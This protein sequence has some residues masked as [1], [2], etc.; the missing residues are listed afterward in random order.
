MRRWGISEA[1]LPPGSIV[2]FREP[3]VWEQYKG[4]IIAAA[5]LCAVEA[6]LI[7]AL[8]VNRRRLNRANAER[9]QA[10]E[11]AH[12]LSGRLINAQEQERSRLARELHDDVTQ[13]LALLA[14][15]AGREERVLPSNTGGKAMRTMREDLV[16]LSEDVHALSYRLHPSILEDLGLVEALK[17]ECN[18]FSKLSPIQ[19]AMNAPEIPVVIPSDTALCLFRVT[20][21]ALRNIARHAEASAVHVS[22]RRLDGGLQLVVQ[23]N[24]IGFDPAQCRSRP[25]LGLASMQ[26][27][28][29][30]LDGNFDIES[31]PGHGTTVL[32]WIPLREKHVDSSACAAG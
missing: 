31:A 13:R 8:L 15:N 32:A 11:A 12:K 20:Q 2:E 30:L 24:G 21:E 23:D 17:C 26:Q 28:I 4:H 18:G 6:I 9:R 16:R 7:V 10:E 1:K 29:S 25:S 14:I 22:L 27:R 19:V 3:T 5:T